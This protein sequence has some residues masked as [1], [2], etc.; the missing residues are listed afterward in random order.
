MTMLRNM[1]M[2]VFAAL[3]FIGTQLEA[4]VVTDMTGRTVTVPEKIMRIA[5]P[6]RI[7][8]EMLLAL[9]AADKIVGV[10]TMPTQATQVFFPE[11][12]HAGIADRHSSVEE[13]LKMKPDVVFNSPGPLVGRLEDAG[14]AVFCIVVEDPDAMIQGLFTIADV[15]NERKKAEEIA[16]YYKEKLTYIAAQ[17]SQISPKKKVY[18]IGPKTLTTIGGDFYQH[19]IIELAGGI[20]VSRELT[21][22]WVSVSREHL[23]AW[24]PDIIV[25]IPYYRAIKHS[26]ILEDNGLSTVKAVKEGKIYTFPSYIDAWDLPSPESILGIMWLANT[27]YPDRVNFDM[28]AEAREFYTRFYGKYPVEIDLEDKNGL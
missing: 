27:L 28:K 26:D 10:S 5:S 21:G 6:Y 24:N 1:L 12:A 3:F 4:R 7:A 22:G 16:H 15:L 11:L 17:T 19:H 25:T 14:I 23:V 13:I 20:N 2:C 9:G 18:I 8:T